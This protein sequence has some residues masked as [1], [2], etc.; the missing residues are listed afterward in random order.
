MRTF[1]PP[2]T[3]SPW[4]PANVASVA[5]APSPDDPSEPLPATTAALPVTNDP[6]EP[7]VILQISLLAVSATNRF[8]ELSTATALGLLKPVADGPAPVQ[9]VPV[10][11]V[12]A[13][14][15][16]APF[17]VSCRMRSFP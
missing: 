3:V 10:A 13:T 14:T 6:S 15:A 11:P 7:L 4:G 16:S 8:P 5:L 2:S 17:G 12:P 1:P 9:P